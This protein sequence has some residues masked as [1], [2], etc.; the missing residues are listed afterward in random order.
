MSIF[1]ISYAYLFVIY[2]NEFVLFPQG[3]KITAKLPSAFRWSFTDQPRPAVNVDPATGRGSGPHKEKFHNYLGIDDPP[4]PIQRHVKWKLARTKR[5]GQMTSQAAQEIS[6]KIDSLEEQ[7]T[8][9]SFAPQGR[10]D[11]LN[12]AI[13]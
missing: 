7:T 8:Q 10:D 1:I 13:G 11:I 9:G 2:I 6:D 5:Y 4:S 3:H 12:T